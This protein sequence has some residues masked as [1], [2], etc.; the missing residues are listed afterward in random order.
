MIRKLQRLSFWL[1]STCA[2]GLYRRFPVFGTLRGAIAII[3]VGHL[4]LVIDRNDGRGLSF[5]GGLAR[6]WESDEA[7]VAR[8]V[9]EETGLSITS[10]SFF[11]KYNLQKPYALTTTIFSARVAGELRTSWEGQP[12]WLPLDSIAHGITHT[13]RPALEKIRSNYFR[14]ETAA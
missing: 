8:E 2:V 14:N 5:P 12:L 3:N 9:F 7:T 13:Q 11:D 1:F 6:P 10:L 4:F